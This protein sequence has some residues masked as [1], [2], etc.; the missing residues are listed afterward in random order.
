MHRL[1]SLPF[2]HHPLTHSTSIRSYPEIK[3]THSAENTSYS[4]TSAFTLLLA[5]LSMYKKLLSLPLT[6]HP[7][8]N[9][10]SI[11][12]Y[13]SATVYSLHTL[14]LTHLLTY[15]AST[16]PYLSFL[17]I[18]LTHDS[19]PQLPLTHPLTYSPTSTFTYLLR[20]PFIFLTLTTTPNLTISSN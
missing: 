5:T 10:A 8:A 19:T 6:H 16:L 4:P 12:S 14:P 3:S 15:S 18:K 7:L 11:R 17:T 1:L 13:H 9:S 20:S 2:T